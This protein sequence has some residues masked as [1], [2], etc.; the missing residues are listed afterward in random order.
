MAAIPTTTASDANVRSQQQPWYMPLIRYEEA[1]LVGLFMLVAIFFLIVEPTARDAS[2]LTSLLRDFS[3]N[4]IAVVGVAIL[5]IAGDFDLSISAMLAV[6]SCVAVEV[7][8]RT[9]S[10]P[11][12]LLVALAV[13][14]LVGVTNGLLVT[15]FH[16]NSL[17]T[18]LGMM[19]TLRGLVYVFTNRTPIVPDGDFTPVTDLYQASLG[20]LPLPAILAVVIVLLFAGVM[21][22][23]EFGRNV[24]AVGGNAHAAKVSGIGVSRLKLALFVLSGTL[25][26]LAALVQTAQTGTGYFD[27]GVQGF[28]LIVIASAVL[29]GVALAGGE[30]RVISAAMGVLI[31]GLTAKGMRLMDIHVTQQLIVTG[32]VMLVAVT[33]HGFRKRTLTRLE[34][35]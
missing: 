23:T 22:R 32:I 16:M 34:I 6:I 30:G 17:M 15:V 18:T 27:A 4:L 10:I 29:G 20:P 8:N 33:Y 12:A 2:H 31:L 24:Y 7:F 3:P 35:G 11:T 28:E 21:A 13:G 5:M 14:P 26:A 1:S 25:A 9:G 19:F